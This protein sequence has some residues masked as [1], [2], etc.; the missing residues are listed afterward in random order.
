MSLVAASNLSKSALFELWVLQM[1]LAVTAV[2]LLSL[3]YV[4]YATLT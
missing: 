3:V 1:G 4:Y 2:L